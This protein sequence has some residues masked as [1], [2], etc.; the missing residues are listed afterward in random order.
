MKIKLNH[1]SLNWQQ[2]A[3]A[4]GLFI[5]IILIYLFKLGSLTTKVSP[6]ELKVSSLPL[7]WHGLYK[8]PLYL[9]LNFLRSI[10]FYLFNN[11][12]SIFLLRLPNVIFGLLS[13]LS[14]SAIAY[15]WHGKKTA[16]FTT[17]MFAS[18][19]WVLH[20]SRL[21]SYDVIYLWAM[22]SAVLGY[23]LLQEYDNKLVWYY[24]LVILGLLT[25]IPG[26]IWLSLVMLFW[27]RKQLKATAIE[28]NLGQRLLSVVL[29]IL[30]LPLIIYRSS[31]NH[32]LKQWLGL[33]QNFPD[34]LK[35]LKDFVAVPLHLL[36]RGP[37]IATLWLGKAPLLDVFSLALL[38][39][40]AYIYF[41]HRRNIRTKLLSSLLVLCVILIG[42]NGSVSFS[43][44][45][46]LAYIL[47]AMGLNYFSFSWKKVFPFNPIAKGLGL[48]LIVLAILIS[49]TYNL[50][51]YFIA[52]PH[53]P[54]TYS[55]FDK[56]L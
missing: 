28:L 12:H 45:L 32:S 18:S 54:N 55:A 25:T 7:G 56:T 20:V 31:I 24:N 10:D 4:S 47:I 1:K 46:P 2:L 8:N 42:L 33:P 51:A 48:G 17:I 44:I 35:Q 34:V 22:V 19:A 5:V 30:W 39:L 26:L 13:I 21:A 15:L 37:E 23:V 53:N 14:L 43:L 11:H 27:Q 38:L 29:L 49:A 52:W 16:Y 40:G 36:I 41:K 9:P 50:K 6:G 3:L